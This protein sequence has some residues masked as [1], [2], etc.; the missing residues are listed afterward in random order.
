MIIEKGK[1]S[2]GCAKNDLLLLSNRLC[3]GGY[4]TFMARIIKKMI[5]SKIVNNNFFTICIMLTFHKHSPF[6]RLDISACEY[7]SGHNRR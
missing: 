1:T 5:I 3:R 7:K 4:F 2:N 6:H